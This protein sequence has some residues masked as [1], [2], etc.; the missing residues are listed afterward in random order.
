MADLINLTFSCQQVTVITDFSDLEQVGREHYMVLNG[1]CA[2]KEELDNL[3]GYETAL[4]LIDEGDG[5]VTPYGV[6]YDNGMCLSQVYDGRH[7]PQYFYEPPLLTLT[8][9]ESKGAPQTWLYLPAP[10]LQIK[11]SLIRAGIVDPA[12][13]EL[14]FQ[15]SEF[16]D[17]VDCVLDM[18]SESLEELNKLCRSIQRLS[19]NE[20]KKLG[21]VVEYAQPETAAQV[22]QLAEN[23]DQF[24]YAPGVQNV[25]E[26]GRYMIQESGR[27]EYDENL[28]DFYDYARYGLERMNSEEGR[29]V[30]SGYV[31][32]HGVLTLEE[33]MMDDPAEQHQAEFDFQMG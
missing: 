5:V 9:Q 16:P 7:F 25:E 29:V 17:A 4:L 32:Y 28:R 31:S 27:F 13:M 24:D 30:K 14:S 6:V 21:A 3:D 33:L 8:V 19:T 2:S 22:R 1:G 11:R 12:D 20:I 23:L 18:K 15:A 10:D 26:Y